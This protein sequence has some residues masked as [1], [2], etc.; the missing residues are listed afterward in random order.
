MEGEGGES[1]GDGRR[2][3]SPRCRPLASCSRCPVVIL[4]RRRVVIV[5]PRVSELGW[6]KLGM[7]DAHHSSFG[8]HVAAGDMAPAS[9]VSVGR[10]CVCAHPFVF[11]LGWS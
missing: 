9:L 5:V 7:G 1:G 8:C 6:D 2:E 11:A 4:Y 10:V 3:W